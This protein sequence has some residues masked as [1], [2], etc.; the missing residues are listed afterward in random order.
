MYLF[1]HQLFNLEIDSKDERYSFIT[2]PFFYKRKE[3]E[4]EKEIR[5]LLSGKKMDKRISPGFI[6][7]Q[8]EFFFKTAG[9]KEIFISKSTDPRVIKAATAKFGKEKIRLVDIIKETGEIKIK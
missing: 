8:K 3:F 5:L 1:G 6:N 7:N 2:M 4:K 9:P